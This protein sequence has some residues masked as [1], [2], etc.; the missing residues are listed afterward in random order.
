MPMTSVFFVSIICFKVV[1]CDQREDKCGEYEPGN[2]SFDNDFCNWST[3]NWTIYPNLADLRQRTGKLVRKMACA[4]ND[5]RHCLTFEYYKWN[6]N[7]KLELHLVA[8]DKGS[9]MEKSSVILNQSSQLFNETF[10]VR[11]QY[12]FKLIFEGVTSGELQL[13][14]LHYVR[15][16][17]NENLSL[18][19]LSS[20][21]VTEPLTAT[22]LTPT[23]YSHGRNF[24]CG[25]RCCCGRRHRRGRPG[26][27]PLQTKE[28]TPLFEDLLQ[29]RKTERKHPH[30]RVA[31][32]S[33]YREY[34]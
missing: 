22:S 9:E 6:T 8:F 15:Q 24:H 1:S 14:N 26:I 34:G 5:K 13:R 18:S 17:C 12:P 25:C 10:E 33:M 32:C 21:T 16:P 27:R 20:K 2:C 31:Q 4:T 23:T 30:A 19:T 29:R 28:A 11:S 3:V 7:D